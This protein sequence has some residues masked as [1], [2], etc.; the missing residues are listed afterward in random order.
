[1]AQPPRREP[2]PRETHTQPEPSCPT[3]LVEIMNEIGRRFDLSTTAG[4]SSAEGAAARFSDDFGFKCRAC[5]ALARGYH[6][7]RL[8]L[9]FSELDPEGSSFALESEHASRSF[10]E[11]VELA[12]RAEEVAASNETSDAG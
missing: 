7:S 5:A 12:R 8:A 4:L 3:W 6:H 9:L 10:R 2:G 11:A 1:M